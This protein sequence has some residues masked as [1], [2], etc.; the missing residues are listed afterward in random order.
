MPKYKARPLNG[1]WA[2][3]PYLH[4][5]SVPNLFELLKPASA[6]D[7]SKAAPPKFTVGN[8]EFDPIHVGYRSDSGPFEFD[9]TLEGNSNVGHEF[10]TGLSDD[11]RFELIE[12]LKTL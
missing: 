10:G 2:T 7:A 8:R 4:N 9:T 6:D 12:Y 3:A 1:I 11:E 5:G